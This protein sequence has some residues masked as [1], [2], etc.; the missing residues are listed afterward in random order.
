MTEKFVV[1]GPN[2]KELVECLGNEIS[3]PRQYDYAY[4][5]KQ[6]CP[7]HDSLP[8]GHVFCG[9]K[10]AAEQIVDALHTLTDGETYTVSPDPR[11]EYV[12]ARTTKVREVV[13]V[14][15]SNPE[16]VADVADSFTGDWSQCGQDRTSLV[17]VMSDCRAGGKNAQDYKRKFGRDI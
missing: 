2:G 16:E 13:R 4:E 5:G 8:E 17:Q 12:I 1:I 3:F 10:D 6:L 9:T 15:A 14:W 7:E 11:I